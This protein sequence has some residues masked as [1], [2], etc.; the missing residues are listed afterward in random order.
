MA[1]TAEL[2]PVAVV[3]CKAL[4]PRSA[5]RR[6][7]SSVR[8]QEDAHAFALRHSEPALSLGED[9]LDELPPP[10]SPIRQRARSTGSL[11]E[12]VES[13]RRHPHRIRI[14]YQDDAYR[15]R[16]E[17]RARSLMASASSS[18]GSNS[19]LLAKKALKY[20]KVYDRMTGVDVHDPAFDV[21]KF[22]GVDWCKTASCK[23]PQ[24]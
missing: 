12:T 13:D 10:A 21:S 1:P 6:M 19:A 15:L 9:E 5:P 22:L 18:S 11:V 17:A 16:S 8:F 3:D 24:E 4:R 23:E 2:A 20:R 14:C 7:V